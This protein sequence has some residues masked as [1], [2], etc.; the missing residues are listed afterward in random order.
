[1]SYWDTSCLVKLYTPEPDSLLFRNKLR[2]PIR[3]VTT[4]VALLEFWATVRRKEAAGVLEIG[5]AAK[6]QSAF[7]GDVSAGLI[8][9]V[10]SSGALHLQFNRTVDRCYARACPIWLRTN[11]ALHLA[12]A[13]LENV[14]EIVATDR[15][16]RD[17]AQFLGFQA[18]PPPP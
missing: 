9:V 3:C 11:D 5:E 10:Q 1:M 17:A 14:A 15:R 7:E 12:A 6:V 8:E 4:E 2:Q 18:F 13:R 16:L